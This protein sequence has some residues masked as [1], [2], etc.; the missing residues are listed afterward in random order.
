MRRRPQLGGLWR[1]GDF[2]KLWAAQTISVFGS[3]ITRTAL[4]FAAILVLDATPLQI[5]L[6]GVADIAPGILSGLVA[7]VWVDRMRR[8][9]IMILADLGR[10]VALVSIPLAAAFDLLRIEHLYA[11]AFLTGIL[12]TFFDVAYLSYLPSLLRRDE[13]LEG[14]SK[15]AA[16][17]SVAEVGAFGLAGWL[18]QIFSAP[19]AILFD[20]IS[21][22]L[23]ASLLRS[24]RTD[25]PEPERAPAEAGPDIRQ[26][27]TA[28]LRVLLRDPLLRALGGSSIALDFSFRI[29][30]TV[31]LLFATRELGFQP[32]ILGLIFAVGGVSSFVGAIVAGRVSGR[33]GIGPAMIVGLILTGVGQLFVP[34]AQSASLAA[35]A[36]L[37][38]Q[39][40]IGDGGAT[41]YLINQ[42]SLRQAVTP[43]QVLG[44]VNA[45][46]QFL[47]LVAMLLGAL[48]GGVLGET[49]GLR[50]TLV[51]GGAFSLL[52]GIALA[53]STV[54]H[55]RETPL[56]LED[57]S[58]TTPAA[59]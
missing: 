32:G 42:V 59:F 19:I 5:A 14:N 35:I 16:T 45:S 58:A 38:A 12:T 37:V 56:V 1:H 40:L 7:G 3:L 50:A 11:V 10:A 53:L 28:G 52:A 29:V 25:E 21:F 36:L 43:S 54:R 22:V 6:L 39:Q 8:R 44:R 9:P 30:G 23:S 18:V 33:L 2:V 48:L 46:I 55:V 51:C 41:V 57:A 26:E 34:L 24:I 13:L 20:A 49:V 15:L 27:V 4:P 31:F 47:G 17:N